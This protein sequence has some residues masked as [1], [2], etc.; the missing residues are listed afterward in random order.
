VLIVLTIV[1][2]LKT[3]IVHTL[4]KASWIAHFYVVYGDKGVIYQ[5]IFFGISN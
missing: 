1:H 3:N 2:L 4:G 5:S